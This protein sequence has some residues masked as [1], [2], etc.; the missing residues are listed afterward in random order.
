MSRSVYNLGL[1]QGKQLALE[2]FIA[3]AEALI[4]EWRNIEADRPGHS[5]RWIAAHRKCATEVAA[6]VQRLRAGDERATDAAPR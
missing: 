1:A 3:R 6:L 2:S 4:A 5:E